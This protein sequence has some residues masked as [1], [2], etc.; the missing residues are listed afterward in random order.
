VGMY[1]NFEEVDL[2][3]DARGASA[4]VV[5]LVVDLCLLAIC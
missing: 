2:E 4:M 5:D 1:Q 3:E